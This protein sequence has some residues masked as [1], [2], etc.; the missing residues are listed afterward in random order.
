MR[1]M[2][3][4]ISE[5]DTIK[6]TIQERIKRLSHRDKHFMLEF[7]TKCENCIRIKELKRLLRVIK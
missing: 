6:Q 5:K 2:I 3:T 1:T 7:N 4:A